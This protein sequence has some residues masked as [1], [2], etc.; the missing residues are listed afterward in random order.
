MKTNSNEV[1]ISIIVPPTSICGESGC[2]WAL[3][4]LIGL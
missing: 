4:C 1:E 2:T 3:V